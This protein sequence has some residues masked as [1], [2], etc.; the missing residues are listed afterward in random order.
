MDVSDLARKKIISTPRWMEKLKGSF[1]KNYMPKHGIT[2]I[3]TRQELKNELLAKEMYDSYQKSLVP[4]T[5]SDL[6]RALS[7]ILY[8]THIEDVQKNVTR[9]IY[10]MRRLQ[11]GHP[12][13]DIGSSALFIYSVGQGTGKSVLVQSFMNAA[14][15]A[16]L[17]AMVG[18]LEKIT[19]NNFADTDRPLDN[20]QMIC[21]PSFLKESKQ[22][23]NRKVLE[24]L[25]DSV[26]ITYDV[27][28]KK[29]VT[30]RF[31]GIIIIGSNVL[32]P[33]NDRRYSVIH[34]V[35]DK[36]SKFANKPSMQDIENACEYLRKSVELD[37]D[38]ETF[39]IAFAMSLVK[40]EHFS[41]ASEICGLDVL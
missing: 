35:E 2:N 28:F 16:G 10:A 14:Q 1:I 13:P 23:V 25:I 4:A 37:E 34:L 26:D 38:D 8:N 40:T 18:D 5:L 31:N 22:G 33:V 19:N 41:E 27:K 11:L 20:Y 9:I 7:V 15:R 6:K 36:L 3:P 39:K 12:D 32:M 29:Y 24:N 17:S 30:Q 21:Q